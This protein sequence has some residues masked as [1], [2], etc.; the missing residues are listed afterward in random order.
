MAKNNIEIEI[1]IMVSNI[2]EFEDRVMA[3]KPKITDEVL[4]KTIRFD[5]NAEDLAKKGLFLRIRSGFKNVLTVKKIIESKNESYLERNEWEID[6]S[7]LE[8]ARQ[9]IKVLGFEKEL[10]MEKYRKKYILPE[11]EITLDRLPF[12]VYAEIE[13]DKDEIDRLVKLLEIDK[14]KII[15]ATYWDLH[16]EYN[17]ANGFIEKNIVFS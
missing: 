11:A 12:G 5:S 15:T 6:I 14:S 7:D 8:I 2:K 4:E 10:I 3:L 9:L 1:K 16:D 17:K 13:A